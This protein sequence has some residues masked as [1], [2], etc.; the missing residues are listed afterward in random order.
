MDRVT[1]PPE[2]FANHPPL[3]PLAPLRMPVQN[4]RRF[5]RAR[6]RLPI[7]PKVWLARLALFAGTIGLTGWLA[8]EMYLVLSVGE[9]VAIEMA[10][11]VLFVINIAWICFGAVSTLLGLFIPPGAHPTSTG[12]I[13]ARTALLLPVYN[14]DTARFVGTAC[15]TLHALREKGAAGCFD[16]FILSDT[17]KADVWLAEQAMIDAARHDPD[18]ANH[19]YYRHRLRNRERKVGNIGDWIERW[20]GAYEFFLVLDADSLMEADTI[21]ELARRMQADPKA[22][23][24][25]TVPRLVNG[26]TALA[27]LQQFASRV[28]GPLLARGLRVWFGDAG[29]YWGHNAIIRTEAFAQSAGLPILRGRKPFGGL[30]LSHDFVE[31]ALIRRNGYSVIMADDLVGSFEQAPPNLIELVAR[32][33]RWCQGNLQHIGLLTTAGLHPISRLHLAMGAMSY[34]ASPLWM[35]FLLAGML[36]A[37]HAS[38]VPPNYFPDGWSLFPVWPQIDAHR[39]MMLFGL[40]MLVLYTP[41]LLGF[42]AFLREPASRGLRIQSFFGFLLENILSALV[43]PVLMLTQTRSVFQILTGRDSG[44]NAQSRDTRRIPWRV[45]WMF[46]R[47]HTLIGLALAVMAGLISWSLLAWMSPALI[48]LGVS[49]PLAAFVSHQGIGD[50]LRRRGLMT[51]PEEVHP[52]AIVTGADAAAEQA[53]ETADIPETIPALL[54]DHPALRRHFAWLD[55]HT[56]REPGEPDPTL[57]AGWLKLTDG[58]PIGKLSSGELYA[59]LAS[60]KIMR[61]LVANDTALD[62]AEQASLLARA[63]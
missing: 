4:L 12:P 61:K 42:F 33:R 26:R 11:L 6:R 51:T 45:L 30:I 37:L 56:Q 59:V 62:H 15:A 28:Y 21:I 1:F 40:C 7:Q 5:R 38:L 35:L 32:D 25:Q 39:A 23:L 29:N 13:T 24:I 18:I 57:A 2:R 48:G 43:A 55:I 47:N 50:W 9:L 27:R 17:N 54:E 44:W 36:L 31:A 46:H 10:M 60:G 34:L 20:G 22:G 41:K 53:A 52:P 49:I 19:L 63:N 3:P 16:L 8:H 14:E 58:I